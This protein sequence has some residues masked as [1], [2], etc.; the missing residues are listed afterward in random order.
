[1]EQMYS[2]VIDFTQQKWIDF[3]ESF[4]QCVIKLKNRIRRDYT[5]YKFINDFTIQTEKG[6][7]V[8]NPSDSRDRMILSI[9]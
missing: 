3:N 2:N 7:L 5:S 9:L 8:F 6:I 4:S 1:M